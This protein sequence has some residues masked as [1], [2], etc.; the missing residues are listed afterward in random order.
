MVSEKVARGHHEKVLALL[1]T[2]MG[3]LVS[4][5][6]LIDHLYSDDPDGGPDTADGLLSVVIFR[7]KQ[8][9]E[10]FGWTITSIGRGSGNKAS[11]RLIPMVA[12]Q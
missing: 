1:S 2:R 6:A 5:D 11:Y 9:I 8:S 4:K 10:P 7:L 12:G 3:R